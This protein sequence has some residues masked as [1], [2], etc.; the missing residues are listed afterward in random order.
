[1]LKKLL[2]ITAVA[3]STF[4][5]IADNNRPLSLPPATKEGFLSNGLHY[6]IMPNDFP[7]HT[8]ECRLVMHVGSINE[9]EMQCGA[10]HFL[11]HMAFNGSKHFP[12][13]TL[14]DYFER[15]GMKYGRDINAF[16][17]FD[18]TAY[19][20]TLPIDSHS[21]NIIDSTL[22]AMGDILSNLTI[23]S[24]RTIRER[25]IILEELRDYNTNDE[26]YDLKIGNGLYHRHIPLGTQE[27]ISSITRQELLNFYHRWYS[28][29]NATVIIVGQVNADDIEQKIK[30]YLGSLPRSF[31]EGVASVSIVHQDY[32]PGI[33]LM[34][35]TDSLNN[36]VKLDLMIP[37]EAVLPSTI[38]DFVDKERTAMLVR[39]L[40]WRQI[41]EKMR[42]DIADTWYLADKSHLSL[43]VQDDTVSNVLNSVTAFA[44]DLKSIAQYG[45]DEDELEYCRSWMANRLTTD[46]YE[47]SSAEWCDD[48]IDRAILH[49]C[50]LYTD[51][52][53]ALVRKGLMKTKSKDIRNIA[54]SIL[55]TFG[56]A[57]L[58]LQGSEGGSLLVAVSEGTFPHDPITEETISSVW[59]AVKAEHHYRFTLPENKNVAKDER[60]LTTNNP[61]LSA[62]HPF[63]EDDVLKRWHYDDIDVDEWQLKNGVTI[64]MRPTKDDSTF[65]I[66]AYGRGGIGN[67]PDSLYYRLS[68][69]VSY[70]DMGGIASIPAD[71]LNAI[72][73]DNG[74]M[75]NIGLANYWHQA[76]ATAKTKDAQ[77]VANLL[78][79]KLTNPGKDSAG[80]EESKAAEL[81]DFGKETI[82]SRMMR[83]DQGRIINN[84]VDSIVGN[85][86]PAQFVPE[87]KQD[88]ERQS[89]DSITDCYKRIFGNPHGLTLIVTGSFQPDSL[90]PI[91]A[92]TFSRLPSRDLSRVESSSA[93]FTVPSDSATYHFPNAD[94]TQA[95][96]S[97]VFVG[98]YKPSLRNTLMFKIMRD[99][100]QSHLI[101]VIRERDNIV[102]SPFVESQYQGVPQQKVWF[103]MYIDVKK[104]NFRRMMDDVNEIADS[105]H[106]VPVTLR[107]LDKIR[108]SFIVTRR[109]ALTDVA[110][111]EWR[112]ALM[113]LV[114]NGESVDDYNRYE[115]V[116]YSI[117]PDDLMKAFREYIN[118]KKLILLVQ[119]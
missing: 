115:D 103:R 62:V 91:L 5:A 61:I 51:A 76:M 87:T 63:N 23:D 4:S 22:V 11:E 29:Q 100:L 37:H 93:P 81:E 99:I 41:A 58:A 109:Q 44:K 116:L 16:T 90:A 112:T 31:P 70:V 48:Y 49:D 9:T 53:L 69:V 8:V 89:L 68:D 67:V 59:N 102:Y 77:A 82:L 80:F 28:P 14:V 73:S 43:T 26:F 24:L 34:T 72:M 74:M 96:C 32:E 95:A 86:L 45:P 85:V 118:M 57:R 35:V 117:T 27:D 18:R 104:D 6:I 111:A 46:M 106:R 42:G 56:K 108:R 1:M 98:N 2:L 110:P 13:G 75:L 17:G 54:R 21:G 113:G 20:Y 107:E 7:R 47:K 10:A 36:T 30:G 94:S 114:E 19:W 65:T 3:L 60:R 52:D 78:Y 50:R 79:E 105:L 97:L 84:K 12:G 88:V 55:P 119:D 15:Q 39:M 25:G 40:Y 92:S 71:T 83:R 33:N 101:A 64:L 38:P 66:T